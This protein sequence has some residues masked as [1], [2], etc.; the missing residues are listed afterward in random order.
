VD[1]TSWKPGRPADKVFEVPKACDGAQK[2]RAAEAT[3]RGGVHA[4]EPARASR[5]M[6]AAALMPWARLSG[7]GGVGAAAA[8]GLAQGALLLRRLAARAEAA[9]FVSSWD[10]QGAGFSVALNRFRWGC[11][12]FM[13]RPLLRAAQLPLLF[14]ARSGQHP[15]ALHSDGSMLH[16]T[17]SQHEMHFHFCGTNPVVHTCAFCSDWLPEEYSALLTARRPTRMDAARKVGD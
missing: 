9:R 3:Q 17:P 4:D 10:A 14:L 7:A 5:V 16:S 15:L 11:R 2:R 6:Q 12:G 1:F 13:G 8:G